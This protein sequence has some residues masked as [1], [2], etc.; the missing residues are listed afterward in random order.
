MLCFCIVFRR[1]PPSRLVPVCSF[2][3]FQMFMVLDQ[4][5]LES[6]FCSSWRMCTCS[7]DSLQVTHSFHHLDAK[8]QNMN[9]CARP[10]P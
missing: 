10:T 5:T 7:C 3:F 8:R 2:M 1:S 6:Q 9:T 4:T